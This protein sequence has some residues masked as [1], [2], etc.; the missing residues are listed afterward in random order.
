M[1]NFQPKKKKMKNKQKKTKWEEVQQLLHPQESKNKQRT[2]ANNR[3]TDNIHETKMK[4]KKII[5]TIQAN[6][7][8][9]SIAN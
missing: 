4:K 5:N 2:R 9:S 7:K 1:L 6:A 8:S 3:L